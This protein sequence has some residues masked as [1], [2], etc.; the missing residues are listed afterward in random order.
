MVDAERKKRDKELLNVK[1]AKV[2]KS[3]E[4]KKL[5]EYKLQAEIKL[6]N[7]EAE[8]RAL[9]NAMSSDAKGN[10]PTFNTSCTKLLRNYQ[11]NFVIN[12]K[13]SNTRTIF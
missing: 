9:A 7:E 12:V 11:G 13:R 8:R 10:R 1:K 6:Q 2:N 3:V 4:N 5:A